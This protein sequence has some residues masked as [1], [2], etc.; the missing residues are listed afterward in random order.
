MRQNKLALPALQA[1]TFLVSFCLLT[2]PTLSLTQETTTAPVASA[3]SGMELRRPVRPWEFIDAVGQHAAFFGNEAGTLEAWVYPLKLFRDFKLRF[4]LKDR[5][6]EAQ[7]YARE[8]VVR[9]EGPSILYATV[10][11]TVRESLIVP[12]EET[13]IFIRLD[14]D[15]FEPLE[16]E[17]QFIRDFQLMW[18]A[19]LGGTFIEWDKQRNI[20]MLGHEQKIYAAVV[21]SPQMA[22]HT[23]EF[24]SNSGLSNLNGL[25]LQ[26]VNGGQTTQF[27]FIAGSSKGPDEALREYEH[28]LKDKDQL[29]ASA[30][31]YYS[32][33]L[34]KTVSLQLPDA[35]MQAAYDWSRVSLIQ[36]LVNNSAL[37][38]GLIAGYRTAGDSSRPG[39]SWFFGR[40]S[41]W[42]DFAFNSMGDFATA[43]AALE[44]ISRFQ[45]ADGK[46]E[47]E[48]PQ[49]ATLVPWFT[50]FKYAYAAADSTPLYILAM[51]DYIDATGDLAFLNQHWDNLWRAYS[52][53]HSTYNAKGLPKNLGIGHG[54]IEGGPLFPVESELYQSGLGAASLQALAHLA[55]LAGKPDIETRLK[56]EFAAEKQSINDLFW[57]AEKS[58]LVF[59]VNEKAERM[60]FAT[61]LSAAAMW[62]DVFDPAKI[63]ATID[64]LAGADHAADWGTRIFSNRN[65][66]FDPTGYHFGSIWPLFTGWASESEYR[67]HRPL[68]AYANLRANSQLALNG[69]AGHV[70]EVLS[71]TYYEPLPESSPHQIWS[72][73]MVV[74]PL[75][76]GLLGITSST[77][78]ATLTVAPHLPADWNRW[79]AS[80]VPACG[81][82]AE[83]VYTRTEKQVELRVEWHPRNSAEAGRGSEGGKGCTL[84]FSPAISLHARAGKNIQVRKTLTDQHATISRPLLPGANFIHIPVTHDFGIVVPAPLPPLGETSQNLKI[85]KE[86]WSARGKS[87]RIEVQG[88]AGMT[89]R[90]KT[91]G[92]RVSSVEGG[93]VFES[94]A[95]VQEVEVSFPLNASSPGFSAQVV[96]LHFP[97]N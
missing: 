27:I 44:F 6:L 72:S 35:Q 90:F 51:N 1:I 13:G 89:Y 21:G 67:G 63:N 32:N 36:G 12:P 56:N 94:G 48:V 61:V 19:G 55:Q 9:P 82:N 96:V 75:L 26:P 45:R 59:A 46:I 88:L 83:L 17:A 34:S 73:A 2:N 85:V 50:D 87:F 20:F 43:R 62:F 10:G 3:T 84:V 91:Y 8:L 39:F 37:G 70:T 57:S 54:W 71:G 24:F 78:A 65:P 79:S 80:H 74:L 18:P 52:F 92:A 15:T 68:P 40:D 7:D 77:T 42:T 53:L 11:F 5:V 25:S 28:L 14:V 33:Y 60:E 81:G 69:S 47:H 22:A 66:L 16:I 29:Q 31:N 4:H 30:R 76:R 86:E 38:R 93:R 97:G 95:G 41:L 64:H 58:T 23:L 49:T